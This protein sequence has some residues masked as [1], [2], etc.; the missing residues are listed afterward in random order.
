M[1]LHRVDG[2]I[3]VVGD[4]ICGLR[5]SS[6]GCLMELSKV[7]ILDSRLE[8]NVGFSCCIKSDVDC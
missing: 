7:V 1:S 3:I 2:F 5:A 8:Y 6:S 4:F